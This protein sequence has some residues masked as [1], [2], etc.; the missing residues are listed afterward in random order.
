MQSEGGGE[1]AEQRTQCLHGFFEIAEVAEA[2]DWASSVPPEKIFI[3]HQVNRIQSKG[4]EAP[5]QFL[6]STLCNILNEWSDVKLLWLLAKANSLHWII[7]AIL[8]LRYETND[9]PTTI[10]IIFLLINFSLYSIFAPIWSFWALCPFPISKYIH[11][12]NTCI[13]YFTF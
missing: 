4:K 13:A 2:W 6:S 1:N 11:T 12:Y 8:P 5:R 10:L 7:N 3:S 9:R